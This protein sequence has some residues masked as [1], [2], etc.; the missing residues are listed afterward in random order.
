MGYTYLSLPWGSNGEKPVVR[1]VSD[2][3][4]GACE[5]RQPSTAAPGARRGWGKALERTWG[6]ALGKISDHGLRGLTGS[7]RKNCTACWLVM[8]AKSASLGVLRGGERCG[9]QIR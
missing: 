3:R 7:V 5:H 2:G 6:E 9:R 1:K 8:H 4:A